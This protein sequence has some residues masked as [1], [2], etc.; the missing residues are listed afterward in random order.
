MSIEVKKEIAVIDCGQ[1]RY[2]K[3]AVVSNGKGRTYLDLRQW[4]ETDDYTGPTKKGL[5]LDW[6]T[7]QKLVDDRVLE[8]AMEVMD[9]LANR[10]GA[11]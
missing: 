4:L 1:G 6:D 3:A 10:G 8:K 9:D 7:L 11:K 2:V 5:W